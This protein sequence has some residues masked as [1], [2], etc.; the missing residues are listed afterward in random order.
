M[1]TTGLEK[2][3]KLVIGIEEKI[4]YDPD[5]SPETFE[6]YKKIYPEFEK[7]FDYRNPQISKNEVWRLCFNLN[8]AFRKG[9]QTNSNVFQDDF[10][11]S[12]DTDFNFNE[13]KEPIFEKKLKKDLKGKSLENAKEKLEFCKKSHHA[14]VNFSFMPRTGNLQGFKGGKCQHD[15]LDIFLYH[16]SKFY[17]AKDEYVLSKAVPQVHERLKTFLGFFND[18]Y[19]YCNK[20]YYIENKGF[21]DRLIENGEK[22]IETADDVI[23]YMDLAIEYWH[24]RA[25]NYAT[26]YYIQEKENDNKRQE[27]SLSATFVYVREQFITQKEAFQNEVHTIKNELAAL[28]VVRDEAIANLDD[29]IVID[30]QIR[31]TGHKLDSATYRLEAC[32]RIH[33]QKLQAALKDVEAEV[34]EYGDTLFVDFET[35]LATVNAKRAEVL[36]EIKKLHEIDGNYKEAREDVRTAQSQA[37][38]QADRSAGSLVNRMHLPLNFSGNLAFSSGNGAIFN[39][40]LWIPNSFA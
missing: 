34:T 8:D 6:H 38:V 16:L 25:V 2:F 31:E 10:Y 36:R 33:E 20:V 11:M 40:M 28:N 37:G 39:T 21:V 29:T 32:D 27:R 9:D 14:L 1:N 3:Y 22:S 30:A 35:Q 12:G 23:R 26:I 5:A 7:I 24:M 15:R 19:H 4:E 17:K 13:K 18:V